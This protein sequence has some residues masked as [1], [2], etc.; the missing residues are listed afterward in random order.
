MYWL[1]M[2]RFFFL[3]HWTVCLATPG[4]RK[5]K[6]KEKKKRLDKG[7]KMVNVPQCRDQ[8]PQIK[9]DGTTRGTFSQ[10]LGQE[11]Y[12]GNGLVLHSCGY[13]IVANLHGVVVN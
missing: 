6:G 1:R 8:R 5:E 2:G 9:G 4:L 11:Y 10:A 12:V 13:G 3:P 7:Q